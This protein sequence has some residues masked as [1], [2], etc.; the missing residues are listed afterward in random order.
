[1][2]KPFPRPKAATGPEIHIAARQPSTGRHA[3]PPRT[4][5]E[6]KTCLRDALQRLVETLESSAAENPGDE[7]SE[8]GNA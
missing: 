3:L 2:P 4:N 1:M 5:E 7:G 8:A 6:A